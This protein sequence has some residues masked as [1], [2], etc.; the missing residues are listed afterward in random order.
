MVGSIAKLGHQ[1]IDLL[2]LFSSSCDERLGPVFF[3]LEQAVGAQRVLRI[4]LLFDGLLNRQ[5]EHA[6]DA[7]GEE[8]TD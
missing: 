8:G 3:N 6:S 4:K 2:I 5:I 7:L 1:V